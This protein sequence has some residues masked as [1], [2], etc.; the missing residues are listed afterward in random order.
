MEL[1]W[2]NKQV[3]RSLSYASFEIHE[4]M[5]VLMSRCRSNCQCRNVDNCWNRT[6]FGTYGHTL[7]EFLWVIAFL[8]KTDA[9]ETEIGI[10]KIRACFKVEFSTFYLHASKFDPVF[11]T[12][13]KFSNSNVWVFYSLWVNVLNEQCCCKTV[14]TARKPK[15]KFPWF[16]W[17]LVEIMYEDD[18]VLEIALVWSITITLVSWS[19]IYIWVWITRPW[20]TK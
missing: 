9:I 13:S 17:D 18:D 8:R 2:Q 14:I 19:H 10:F 5:L 1:D 16:S 3:S 20:E 7:Y 6:L 12:V 4:T 11:K 15:I